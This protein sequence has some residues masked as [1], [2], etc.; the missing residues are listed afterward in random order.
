MIRREEDQ[1]HPAN[2]SDREGRVRAENLPKHPEDGEYGSL[3]VMMMVMTRL[4]MMM[5]MMVMMM[6]ILTFLFSGSSH[7]KFA[8]GLA[9]RLGLQVNSFLILNLHYCH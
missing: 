9:D 3:Q 1:T 5:A 8:K 7:P 2:A 6:M 4:M